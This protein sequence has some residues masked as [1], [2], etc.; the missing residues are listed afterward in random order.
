M[1]RILIEIKNLEYRSYNSS[2]VMKIDH[3]N[4]NSGKSLLISGES[5]SGKTT[6]LNLLSGTILAQKGE[7]IILGKSLSEFSSIKKDKIRGDNFGIIF[8][9][10]NLLPYLSVEDNV[11][12]GLSFS[13]LRK[14]RLKGSYK[15]EIE[16]LMSKLSLN[17]KSL[18]NRKASELSI[19][20]QQRIAVARALIGNPEIILADEPTSAL[21]AKN[22]EE[23]LKLLF[24]SLDKKRQ[25]LIV[26]SHDQ[27]L[28]KNFDLKKSIHDICRI[29]END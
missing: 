1:N 14:S 18:M 12:L 25:S 28:A 13:Q 11:L 21:D 5:G 15:E 16:I 2:F 23:F 7:I 20:Q 6:F 29:S 27:S 19:G 10:F 3:F 17:Y 26:V 8:Q 24:Q 22:K 4:L 9:T